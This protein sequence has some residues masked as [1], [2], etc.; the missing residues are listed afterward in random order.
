MYLIL[1]SKDY[2]NIAREELE[3]LLQISLRPY[4]DGYFFTEDEIDF[5]LVNRL[6]LTR[7]IYEVKAHFNTGSEE[8]VLSK[9]DIN[10]FENTYKIDIVGFEGSIGYYWNN[11]DSVI[12][13]KS[14]SVT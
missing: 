12:I 3:T 2:P 4:V 11:K 5:N 13:F 9:L 1:I 14:V 10:I 7:E 8:K 6:G